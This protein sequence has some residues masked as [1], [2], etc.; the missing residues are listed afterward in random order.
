MLPPAVK[1][2]Q[3]DD[4]GERICWEYLQR[5][6]PGARE[7]RDIDLLLRAEENAATVKAVVC[8]RGIGTL[9]VTPMS[10]EP[11]AE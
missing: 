5:R 10:I 8:T 6:L 3:Y 2:Y 4:V 11:A 9:W 7:W 1:L